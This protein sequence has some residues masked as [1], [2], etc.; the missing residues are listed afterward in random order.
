M[1]SVQ[2]TKTFVD[3]TKIW[4]QVKKWRI[5]QIFSYSICYTMTDHYT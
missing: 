5:Q 1:I 2:S 3:Y 4:F